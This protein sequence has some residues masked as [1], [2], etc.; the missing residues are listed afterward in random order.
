M[1]ELIAEGTNPGH[2]ERAVVSQGLT[3]NGICLGRRGPNRIIELALEQSELVRR[4]I[5]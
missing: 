1:R 2:I 5:I 3:Q 4:Q